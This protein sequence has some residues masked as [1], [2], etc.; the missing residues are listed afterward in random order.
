MITVVTAVD[1][2]HIKELNKTFPTWVKYKNIQ[3]SI[4]PTITNY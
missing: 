1:A 2:H 4:K 3:Q